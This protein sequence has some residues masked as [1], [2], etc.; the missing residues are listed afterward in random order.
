MNFSPRSS[1]FEAHF[2]EPSTLREVKIAMA[3]LAQ[4][5]EL[6]NHNYSLLRSGFLILKLD[7]EE[8]VPKM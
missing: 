5:L 6:K 2:Q 8:N 4:K 7:F 1:V 3:I